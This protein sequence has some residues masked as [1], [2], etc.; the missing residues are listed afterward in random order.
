MGHNKR[1]FSSAVSEMKHFLLGAG[2]VLTLAVVVPVLAQTTPPPDGG[3]GTYT[4]PPTTGSTTGTYTA[5]TGGSTGTMPTQ[6]PPGETGTPPNCS[7]ATYTAPTSGTTSTQPT[8]GAY[9]QPTTGTQT[10]PTGIQPTATQTQPASGTFYC[11]SLSKQATALECDAAD[12]AKGF[13]KPSFSPTTSTKPSSTQSKF[14]GQGNGVESG[15]PGQGQGVEEGFPGM[16]QK[17]QKS[18]STKQ[19]KEFKQP[20]FKQPTKKQPDVSRFTKNIDKGIAVLTK[21]A[22][23]FNASLEKITSN[24]DYSDKQ[25][26]KKALSAVSSVSRKLQKACRYFASAPMVEDSDFDCGDFLIDAL[27]AIGDAVREKD[28][29]AAIENYTTAAGTLAEQLDV[30]KASIEE[31]ANAEEDEEEED[32]GGFGG[33]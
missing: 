32:F 7:G 18:S 17:S 5:P 29:N 1:V 28:V 26:V 8:S 2:L 12:D 33:F 15:F 25:K 31:A 22:D 24:E 3:T 6:C 11:F 19:R 4:P 10:Q 30:L 16:S 13:T 23:K 9:T 20:E 14:P 27:E 21:D